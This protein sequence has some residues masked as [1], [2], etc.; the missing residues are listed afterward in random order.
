MALFY[1][2]KAPLYK[3]AKSVDNYLAFYLP[4]WSDEKATALVKR[5]NAEHTT[6]MSEQDKMLKWDKIDCF[7]IGEQD[8]LD[9]A[10]N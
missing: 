7:Y 3:G 1:K 6:G 4:A 5:C 2:S 10:G 9:T 8:M